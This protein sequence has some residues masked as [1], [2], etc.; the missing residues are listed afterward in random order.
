M[1]TAI[2]REKQ[3]K[4]AG[5]IETINKKRQAEIKELARQEKI[6][7]LKLAGFDEKTL[8]SEFESEPE[9]IK[10]K[11]IIKSDVFGSA[12]AIKGSIDGLG[13]EEVKSVVILHEAGMP[14]D[15]DVDRAKAL[16]A[17]ILCFN[18]KIPKAIQAKA[19][20]SLVDVKEYNIIYRLIE[21][22]TNE[23]TSH[24]KPHIE[25]KILGEVEIKDV[26]SITSKTKLKFKIAGCKVNTGNIK[27]SSKIKVLEERMRCL[28]VLS[29]HLNMLRMIFLRP[30]EVMN[31]GFH[32]ITGI[33]S[34]LE[35]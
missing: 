24:L 27:R 33:N 9:C 32:L 14:S 15:S 19:D 11:Y 28:M 17:K 34:K 6:N 2:N 3:I 20:K 31:V 35:T 1:K 22:V 21:D 5:D 8:K 25:T 10:V 23:L 16:D 13:N 18:V 26:F 7:E 4:A 12:E 29:R 30:R